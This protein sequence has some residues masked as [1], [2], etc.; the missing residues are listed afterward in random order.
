MKLRTLIVDDE[1]PARRRMVKLIREAPDCELAGEA[2]SGAEAIGL[3]HSLRPNLILLDIQLKDMTGFE[4]LKAVSTVFDGALIF[5]TAFDEHAIQ[6]FEVNA[7]DYLL[8]PYKNQRFVQA[9]ERAHRQLL[10]QQQPSIADLL[11][12]LQLLHLSPPPGLRIPEGKIMHYLDADQLEYVQADGPYARFYTPEQVKTIRI[13]LKKA[14]TLLP[15]NFVRISRSVIINRAKISWTKNLKH[16]I[17]IAMSCG[18]Q[19]VASKDYWGGE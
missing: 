4:V 14:T 13:S 16:S 19:F 12:Q 3:I 10:H 15:E 18:V 1:A 7:V 8:K 9:I 6:A 5:I 17:E 2:E 11:E